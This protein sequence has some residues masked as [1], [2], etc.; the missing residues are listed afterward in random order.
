MSL[1]EL[2]YRIL[3]YP[4][5]FLYEL[6]FSNAQNCFHNVVI[7]II[8]LSFV[9]NT[10]ALPLYKR[11]ESIQNEERDME[12]KMEKWTKHIKSSFKGDER[13]MMIQYY[14]S[15]CGY[16]QYYVLRSSIPLL[17][18]VPF[19]MAAYNFLSNLAYLN[20][21]NIGPITN[22]AAPDGLIT[23]GA[24]SINVLPI[25]MTLIN[26]ISSAVYAKGLPAKTQFQMY[27]IAAVFLVLLYNSPS[28][29]VF[30][31]L[32]NNVY[33]LCKN[34]ILKLLPEKKA[35]KIT[36]VSK[37]DNM[38][39]LTSA[40]TTAV[41]TGFT[42]PAETLG[43]GP[44]DFVFLSN[45]LNPEL[46]V[47][48]AFTLA[49]GLFFVW[50]GIYYLL[51]D[52]KWKKV[53]GIVL[54]ITATVFLYNAFVYQREDTYI[55]RA[56]SNV[57][58]YTYSNKE[59]ISNTT[60]VI[61]IAAFIIL[62]WKYS[63]RILPLIMVILLSASV[64][65][66]VFC[67]NKITTTTAGEYYLSDNYCTRAELNLSKDGR[68]VVV[69]ML[70]RAIG[71]YYPYMMN[72]DSD[73]YASFEG[74]TYYSNA[75]S[76]S[77][78]TLAG[79]P[80]LYGG[81]EYSVG[82][83][84]MRSDVLISDKIN[85]ALLSLPV[86]MTINGYNVTVTNPPF[87]GYRWIPDLSMYEACGIDAYV[88]QGGYVDLLPEFSEYSDAFLARQE[89]NLFCYGISRSVPVFMIDFIHDGG[90]YGALEYCDVSTDISDSYNVDYEESYATLLGLPESTNI[91]NDASYNFLLLT[92]S[93]THE[94][95]RQFETDYPNGVTDWNNNTYYFSREDQIVSYQTNLEVFEAIGA[96]LDY[97]KA[98]G[99]YDN[100]RIIIVSD[101][102][103][104]LN[105]YGDW[106]TDSD[107]DLSKINCIL[108]Y[109]D[110]EDRT[111]DVND[112]FM[113]N[114]IVPYLA[115]NGLVENP[116]NPFSGVPYS[117]SYINDDRYVYISDMSSP[118]QN[119]GSQFVN[120][121]WYLLTGNSYSEYE[122]V[123]TN[124][125]Q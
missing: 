105:L 62:V 115:T 96:W 106:I 21:V 119:T 84:N 19:F 40:V 13:F 26:V 17:L 125:P 25:L 120:G 55:S 112:E 31:W 27:A 82:S 2:L 61:L 95:T 16:K 114:A 9:V 123:P 51:L 47:W 46:L 60:I 98:E 88:T 64:F 66:G 41:F 102:G 65:Y 10:L 111:N 37:L 44:T 30:Y 34:I 33:S 75:V 3:I 45:Y 39:F 6:V 110:F 122:L 29:L 70:D 58:F 104:D 93:A 38:V 97:L 56:F 87:A 108:L 11:A 99:V 35:K 113:T 103:Y 85:E 52:G 92:N 76:Y 68:N 117:L 59:L 8:L 94:P 71:A 36:K 32:L 91:I 80:A 67:Y 12:K 20:G 77:G 7:S 109:K 73:L 4:L 15:L 124:P 78:F 18:Q 107:V 22:L 48:Y 90:N 28:G 23:I 118:T 100:T 101:H 74:F 24:L 5:E 14:Y 57:S 69:L 53:F 116:A 50:T 43:R 79:S 63:K 86:L 42:I 1:G 81:P 121:D 89:R 72:E 49:V 54:S 83:M